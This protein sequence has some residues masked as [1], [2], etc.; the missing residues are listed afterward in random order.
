MCEVLMQVWQRK[1]INGTT[2]STDSTIYT[3]MKTCY[4]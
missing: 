4:L 3:V 2:L 1:L